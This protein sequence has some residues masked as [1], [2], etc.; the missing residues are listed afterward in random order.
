MKYTS[1]AKSDASIKALWPDEPKVSQVFA[2]F[3]QQYIDM[4]EFPVFDF[5]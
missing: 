4:G 5:S 3:F 1:F 2:H